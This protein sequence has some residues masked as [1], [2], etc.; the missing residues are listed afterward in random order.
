VRHTIRRTVSLT[1]RELEP[2]TGL[3]VF[4]WVLREMLTCVLQ[5]ASGGET[6]L[7]PAGSMEP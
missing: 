7:R 5:R 6:S 1:E 3:C 4:V 2:E